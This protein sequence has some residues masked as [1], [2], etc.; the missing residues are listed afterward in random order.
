MPKVRQDIKN[1]I[2]TRPET[3]LNELVGVGRAVNLDCDISLGGTVSV[4]SVQVHIS[5][6]LVAWLAGSPGRGGFLD[7]WSSA[8]LTL[9]H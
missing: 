4:E 5:S 9:V 1:W 2:C 7:S 8:C 3:K 6:L